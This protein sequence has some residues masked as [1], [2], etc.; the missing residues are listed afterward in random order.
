MAH[1]KA[2]VELLKPLVLEG[3]AV[4]RDAKVKDHN[5]SQKPEEDTWLK[6]ALHQSA[7]V[8]A[9]EQD[10]FATLRKRYK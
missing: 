10:F 6:N 8:E 3:P 4:E 5:D 1:A 7:A 2:D 9:S